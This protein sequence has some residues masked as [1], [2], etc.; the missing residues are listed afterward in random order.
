MWGRGVGGQTWL[1]G[2]SWS[3][4]LAG[5]G[6]SPPWGLGGST[7]LAGK[8]HCVLGEAGR[9]AQ[10]RGNC[11]MVG[12]SMGAGGGRVLGSLLSWHGGSPGGGGCP[13][14]PWP[15]CGPPTA[16]WGWGQ[17][18]PGPLAPL[19][20]GSPEPPPQHRGTWTPPVPSGATPRFPSAPVPPTVP[21]PQPWGQ[22]LSLEGCEGPE[23]PLVR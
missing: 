5:V 3:E 8:G 11:L 7:T 12:L 19:Q 17:G 6:S 13:R 18:G 1:Q 10:A 9:W 16:R 22:G 14:S 21:T 4:C 20:R 23:P 2:D 15:L